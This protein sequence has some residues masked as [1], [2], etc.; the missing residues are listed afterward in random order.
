MQ[1]LEFNIN[2]AIKEVKPDFLIYNAGTDCME[3]DPLG[4]SKSKSFFFHYILLFLGGLS[5]TENGIIMRDRFMFKVCRENRIPILMVL[6]G[7]Y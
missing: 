4:K 7:G 6:S 1:A 3:G 5:I 2:R